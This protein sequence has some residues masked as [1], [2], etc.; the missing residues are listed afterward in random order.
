MKEQ[1]IREELMQCRELLEDLFQGGLSNVPESLLKRLTQEA[2]Y[3]G[4]FGMAWLSERLGM[5]AQA[6]EK[7]RHEISRGGDAEI[8]NLFCEISV[9]L[10]KGISQSSLDEAGIRIRQKDWELE[11]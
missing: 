7:R 4:Q 8:C 11:E 10:E 6:L 9:F 1:R 5:L 3:V 2:T